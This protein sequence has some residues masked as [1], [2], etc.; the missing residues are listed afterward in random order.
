MSTAQVLVA[1]D[2]A[3]DA[4]QI[5]R[6]LAADFA[7]VKLSTDGDR[8]LQEFEQHRPDVLVL[9]FDALDKAQ[10]YHLGL[11]RLGGASHLHAHRTV[12]LCSKDEVQA[13]F[14][15]CKQAY[16]D[17]YVLYWPHSHDG[18]RLAMSLWNAC[19]AA[20]AVRADVPRPAE[21]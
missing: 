17:D 7:N 21:L 10:R 20:T 15:L 19:R 9:A 11:Y 14:A 16:F 8:F 12:I 4:Q 3:D 13:V 2:N 1:S 6:Q 5:G 18:T